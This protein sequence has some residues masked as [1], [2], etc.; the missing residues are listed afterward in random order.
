[1]RSADPES[2]ET[3]RPLLFGIAYR[4]LGSA[5]DAEDIV[6]ESFVRYARAVADGTR[7][8]SLKAYLAAIT[9]RLALDHAKSARVRREEYVGL[10]LPEPL[11]TDRGFVDAPEVD[12]ESDSLSTA[13]LLLLERLTPAER[14][15]FVLHDVFG[16][17]FDHVS[18]MVGKTPANTRKIATR[19]RAAVGSG[20]RLSA[21]T[22]EAQQQLAT[23]FFAAMRTGDVE[24]LVEFLS[25]R[26]VV[27][28]DGGGKAPQ[29]ANPIEGPDR[30]SRLLAGLGRQIR[31]GGGTIEIR[32]INGGPG[33]IVRDPDG[34]VVSTFSLEITDGRI[35]VLRSVINPDKLGRIGE[36]ADVR[37]LLRRRNARPDN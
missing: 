24:G 16:Y 10:W 37:E 18:S 15:V 22:R 26:V 12:P 1:M 5:A 23:R 36:V 3:H 29:W 28:G 21:A 8:D 34:R 25:D 19:A 11:L 33:A 4:M 20:R 32:E 31:D 9:T 14:A 6:Q 35:Q 7:I 30:V 27:Q 17:P 13:F 2:F